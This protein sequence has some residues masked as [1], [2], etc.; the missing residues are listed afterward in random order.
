MGLKYN[1]KTGEF[2]EENNGRNM[3]STRSHT[4]Y[5][6]NHPSSSSY[7]QGS[8]DSEGCLSL[9]CFFVLILI[10]CAVSLIAYQ[11]CTEASR[12]SSTPT[13]TNVHSSYQKVDNAASDFYISSDAP[14]NKPSNTSSSSEPAKSTP[15]YRTETFEYECTTCNGKGVIPCHICQGKGIVYC[16]H[17]CSNCFG[18]G[19]NETRC[20]CG[21][22]GSCSL[23]DGTGVRRSDCLACGGSG[24]KEYAECTHCKSSLLNT[25]L[26]PKCSGNGYITKTRLVKDESL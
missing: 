10:G 7:T 1:D 23:C 20:I 26:C 2:E 18:R 9:I 11:A 3:S 5:K 6:S 8:D 14:K 17:K 12:S 13:P 24:T 25:E 4:T 19:Y 16:L 21:G 22:F 15:S